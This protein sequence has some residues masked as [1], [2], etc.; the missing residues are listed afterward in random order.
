MLG[1]AIPLTVVP[2]MAQS[3]SQG[4]VQPTPA[5]PGGQAAAPAAP[6]PPQARSAVFIRSASR[7]VV[8]GRRVVVHG[9]LRPARAGRAVSLQIRRSARWVTV[10]RDRTNGRG[11]FRLRFRPS[12]PGSVALRVRSA[13]DALSAG[14]RKRLGRLNVFRPVFVSW[15]GPGFYGGH[16]A[17]GGTLGY[18]TLGVAHKTLPCGTEV[19]LSYRGRTVRVPVIDRGPYVAGREYDLTG[20]TRSALGF[21]STGTILATR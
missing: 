19:T 2:A 9:L 20:A 8:A 13:G 3:D 10:A 1:I 5:P 4:S 21:G 7:N 17:C 15:Y 18:G 6:A 16:L 12:Q 14:A 11:V